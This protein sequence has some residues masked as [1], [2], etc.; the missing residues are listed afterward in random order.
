MGTGRRQSRSPC[1]KHGRSSHW[2]Y[3]SP[4]LH[5]C[6]PCGALFTR[7]KLDTG[8]AGV[9]HWQ[10]GNWRSVQLVPPPNVL[11]LSVGKHRD[12]A[13]HTELG[14]HTLRHACVSHVGG[15]RGG[16]AGAGGEVWKPVRRV[17]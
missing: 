4:H 9:P 14:H 10:T 2:F 12:A 17:L 7:R 1:A 16:G 15:H 11:V 13:G 3:H 8:G 5:R 6:V